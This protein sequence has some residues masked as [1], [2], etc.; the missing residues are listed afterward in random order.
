[1]L[2]LLVIWFGLE[3]T[4]DDVIGALVPELIGFSLEGIFFIGI[5]TWLQEKRE[6]KKRIELKQSL[7]GAL[8]FLCQLINGS[9]PPG[10]QITLASGDNWTRQARS[11]GRQ[12][13]RLLALLPQQ[14]LDIAEAQVKAIQQLLATRRS[15]RCSLFLTRSVTSTC[16]HSPSS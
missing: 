4:T 6:R 11:G 8:R 13:A 14:K 1:L 10:N 3:S 7:A 9:L 15:I 12:L 2:G 5:L 16:R